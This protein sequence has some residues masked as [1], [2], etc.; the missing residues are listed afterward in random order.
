MDELQ[1]FK[2]QLKQVEAALAADPSNAELKKLQV[3]LQ[4]MIRLQMQLL[5]KPQPAAAGAQGAR[6][7][8]SVN[9]ECEAVWAQ[10]GNYY[11]AVIKSLSEDG[12]SA[13]VQFVEYGN[14]DIVL[15]N[16]L[17]PVSA[18][19]EV[20]DKAAKEKRKLKNLK[21]K[22]KM[23]EKDKVFE[24]VQSSWQSF[25]HVKVKSKE[26]V[27]KVPKK[28]IFATPDSVTG[29]VGIGTCN[30]GGKGMTSFQTREKWQFTTQEGEE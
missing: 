18:A 23:E 28:S 12:T 26:L 20:E 27:N 29:K 13:T 19:N 30:I 11:K 5:N 24:K 3:D 1:T 7:K 9:D 21:K 2:E 17:R 15:T 10:D 16:S 6:K 14:A 4:E 22:Q 25:Q 8:W